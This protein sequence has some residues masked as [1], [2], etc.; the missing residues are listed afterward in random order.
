MRR[1]ANFPR[2][3]PWGSVLRML[4]KKRFR[5][6]DEFDVNYREVAMCMN[7]RYWRVGMWLVSQ[8]VMLLAPRTTHSQQS[9]GGYH[10]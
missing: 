8:I 5:D 4:A 3:P 2:Q 10:P 7:T 6:M 9:V 1:T